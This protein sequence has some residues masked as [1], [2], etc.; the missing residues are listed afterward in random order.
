MSNYQK[1]TGK[2]KPK[3]TGLAIF[4]GLLVIAAFV[5][6]VIVV[7]N[8]KSH[9]KES[10]INDVVD[11]TRSE[12]VTAEFIEAVRGDIQEYAVEKEVITGEYKWTEGNIPLLTKTGFTLCYEASVK[13]GID[14]EVMT[15]NCDE[16]AIYIVIPHA[17][18]LSANID[19]NTV[20]F[21]NERKAVFNHKHPEDVTNAIAAAEQLASIQAKE[22]GILVA[23][24]I[25]IEKLLRDYFGAVADGRD[26]VISFVGDDPNTPRV[27]LSSAK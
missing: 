8:K 1:S 19:M 12:R 6:S 22:Q 13:A 17:E 4:S 18:I 3:R 16:S 21:K 26:V 23:A 24:D 5:V 10:R 15:V 7:N 11:L 20:K 2:V 9:E 25:R 27:V 14:G